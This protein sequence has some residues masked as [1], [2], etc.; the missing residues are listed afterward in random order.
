M[1]CTDDVA[2]TPST[3]NDTAP[4]FS[5]DA[6]PIRGGIRLVVTG[7]LDVATAP[8]FAAALSDALGAGGTVELDLAGVSFMDSKGLGVLVDAQRTA[9][10]DRPIGVAEASRTVRKLLKVTGLDR[11][12][13]VDADD[14]PS[15]GIAAAVETVTADAVDAQNAYEG[16]LDRNDDAI[17]GGRNPQYGRGAID[18][19]RRRAA[20]ARDAVVVLAEATGAD[21]PVPAAAG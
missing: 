12:F 5:A 10:D 19:L 6:T 21:L 11:A 14:A 9:G 4:P 18:V 2:R 17:R 8:A 15:V 13:G 16:A 3:P 20:D 1:P 7:E